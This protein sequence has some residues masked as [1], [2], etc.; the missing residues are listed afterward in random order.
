MNE[1][2]MKGPLE[3]FEEAAKSRHKEKD[4]QLRSEVSGEF[5]S[6]NSE[7]PG[8]SRDTVEALS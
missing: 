8:C 3:S 7:Y 2:D 6:R 4:V 5:S 1:E